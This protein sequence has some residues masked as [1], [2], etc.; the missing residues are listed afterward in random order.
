M[1]C[2]QLDAFTWSRLRRAEMTRHH[3][4][5]RVNAAAPSGPWAKLILVILAC[6]LVAGCTLEL[7]DEPG[8]DSAQPGNQCS[9]LEGPHGGI[10]Q[11][12]QSQTGLQPNFAVGAGEEGDARFGLRLGTA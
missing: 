10:A 1:S 11:L 12:D 8:C 7:P 4:S 3:G 5:R 6:G 2:Y 9:A